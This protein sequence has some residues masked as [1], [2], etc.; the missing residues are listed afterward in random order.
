[1]YLAWLH[2]R[3][4]GEGLLPSAAKLPKT[5]RR[6]VDKAVADLR[7]AEEEVQKLGRLLPRMR[8]PLGLLAA[9]AHEAA[10][11]LH[12]NPARGRLPG[13]VPPKPAEVASLSLLNVLVTESLPVARE[14]D[15][16]KRAGHST[17]GEIGRA[18]CR[19]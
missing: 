17:R 3:V 6:L 7:R 14:E 12:E 19:E 13:P 9:T 15:P 8:G 4:V 2:R 18:S 1:A 10:K 5:D 16:V 11:S